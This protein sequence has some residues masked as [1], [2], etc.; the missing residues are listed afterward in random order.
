MANRRMFSLDVVDTDRFMEMPTTSQ[1]LYFHLGMRADDDGFVSS[2]KKITRSANCSDD[3]LKL[4]ITKGYIIPFQSGVV[5]ITHWNQNN[6]VQRDRYKE[7][8]FKIERQQLSLMDNIYTAKSINISTLDTKCIHDVSKVDT[9]VRLGKDSI[10]KN[11][12]NVEQSPTIYPYEEII[13]Y[14]NQ[15][16]GKNFKANGKETQKHINARFKEGFTLEDFKK[17]IDRKS[18]AWKGTE[19]E[20]Y[21]RPATLFGTKFDS[22]LNE[23]PA[24]VIPQKEPEEMVESVDYSQAE[25]TW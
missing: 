15:K 22:Y 20:R 24:A 17:V 18:A 3:D 19:W 16:T 23:C 25:R 10:D 1:A 11:K 9:Q 14:L 6:H 4:L 5:V 2:P 21:L 8:Q 13:N 12:Y 7:T